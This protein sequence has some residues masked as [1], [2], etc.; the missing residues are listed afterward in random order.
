MK[1]PATLGTALVVAHSLA[2]AVRAAVVKSSASDLPLV[3][4][5]ALVDS[6]VLEDL[7]ECAQALEDIAYATPARNRVHGSEGHLNT[8]QYIIDELKSVGDYWSIQQQPVTTEVLLGQESSLTIDGESFETG[9]FEFSNNGTWTDVPLVKIANHGCAAEDVPETVHGNVALI[10]RGNCTFVEKLTNAGARGAIAALI[11]NDRDVG[12]AKGTLGDPNDLIAAMG[13]TRAAGQ[14]LASS[15]AAAASPPPR[16]TGDH[17]TARANATSYN[18]I[19]ES[20]TGDAGNVLMLGA[21]A[22]SVAAGPG[23]NDNGSGACGLLAVAKRLARYS[24]TN[25][26]RVAWWTAEEEGLLGAEAWV[27][28]AAYDAPERLRRRLRLYLNFDML[29]SP[30]YKLGV[31]DGDGDD[32]RRHRPA[33]WDRE[34]EDEVEPAPAGSAQAEALFAAWFRA[35]GGGAAAPLN[36]RSDYGPFLDAGVPC[37]GLDTGA[38]A[39]KTAGEAARF[40][41]VAGAWYDPNYHSAADNVTNLAREAFEINA[42]AIAHAVATYGASWEGFP[43]R[44]EPDD[45][46][47]WVARM[48][49]RP[50]KYTA[51]GKKMHARGSKELY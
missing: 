11:Y 21:H 42:K 20:A 30:N 17:W 9:R 12:L 47:D 34:D 51:W 13:L 28:A 33:W 31:Y 1:A 26:V 44:S 18:V 5:E 16:S 15:L 41:G 29:A 38:D 8:V 36:G 7:M 43:P 46:D 6:I 25:R 22:D 4:D 35:R 3:D 27:A 24:T 39:A 19:A 49:V 14:R 2:A 48:A 45:D 50:G 40:G 10:E 23:I 32:A 37:G